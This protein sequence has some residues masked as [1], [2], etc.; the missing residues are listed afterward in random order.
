MNLLTRYM[1]RQNLYLLLLVCG[2]GLGIYIF[3][4]LLDRL[5]DFLDAGVGFSSVIS[6]F[7]YR[8]PFIL[9]QIFPAVFLIALMVQLGIMLRS[10]ELLALEA[11][12][13][14]PKKVARSVICYALVLCVALLF[15]SEVLG[16]SGHK[17]ADRIWY[18]Q[19][20]DRQIET[21]SLTDIWFREGNRIVHMGSVTPGAKKGANLT[22]HVLDDNDAG[23]IRE[24]IRAASFTSSS[25][26][27]LLSDA[28]RTFPETFEVRA[29]AEL[30][31]DLRTDVGGFLIIDPKTRLESLPI[32]Q[33]GSEIKR[34]E[35]SGSNIERLQTAWHMKLAYAGSV[36]VMAFI[37]L[38]V[39]SVFGS[40][41]V[42]IP[43]GLVTT[44]CYYGLFVLC[45]T[46]GE[47]GLAPP[48]LAAWAA[49]L[50]FMAVAGGWLMRGRSFH[51]G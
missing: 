13:V 27:W 5:D 15:F 29:M 23:V 43:V 7:V 11:C 38:A 28:T 24:I 48:V 22:I 40:L 26:G 2:I 47:K 32:W 10:R 42:I 36:L 6:Y 34:L 3:I 16:V 50:I 18:E 37:A 31:L 8:S 49:N 12:A 17:A 19:V 1:L 20:R 44:F 51:L 45:A 14:S 39:V 9:S 46:A 4:D 21:R 41:F 35:D 33:L 25:R 30:E